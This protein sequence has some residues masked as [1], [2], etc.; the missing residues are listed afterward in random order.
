MS[1]VKPESIRRGNLVWADAAPTKGSEQRGD[2]PHL[3]IT[4]SRFHRAYGLAT[5]V[6]ATTAATRGRK[7]FPTWVANPDGSGHFMVEQIRALS[8]ERVRRVDDCVPPAVVDQ[9]LAIF[10]HMARDGDR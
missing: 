5:V 1:K 3:V 10:D 4:N 2:R 7:P 8:L 9:V 6:P